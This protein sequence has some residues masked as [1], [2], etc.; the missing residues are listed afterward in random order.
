MTNK[1]NQSIRGRGANYNPANRF[2]NIELTIDIDAVDEERPA[3]KTRFFRDHTKT[4]IAYN[5]SPDVGFDASINPYRG[6]EHGCVYCYARPTHE[7]VGLSAGLDFESMIFVKE[8]APELLDFELRSKR[9]TPQVLAFSG[10]TDCYQPVERTLQ[11]TRGCLDVL[12][13]FR[14]PCF[15]VTKNHLVTRDIDLLQ[16]LACYHCTG[17]F[18][19]LSS[20]NEKLVSVLE[21]R[22]ARPQKRL[23]AIKALSDAGIPTG[24]MVAPVIP[25]LNDFEIPAVVKAAAKAGAT[26]ANY[27]LLRLP[28]AVKDLFIPFLSN[29]F[30]NHKNKVLNR[31]KHIRDGKLN[32]S[33]FGERFRGQGIFAEQIQ[34]MF[35]KSCQQAEILQKSPQLR[36]GHFKIPDS[37]P[38]QPLFWD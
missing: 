38:L 11:L 10:V 34:K 18:I 15:I 13:R 28:H 14:N 17:V 37:N 9:W 25:G 3:P 16:E 6:C 26:F 5:Q 20:L 23:Q 33:T 2:D 29:N 27:I 1:L 35:I 21:P 4:I 19:S 31:I 32:C 36:S 22:T 12:L 24:V 8:K 30:P 7:Y